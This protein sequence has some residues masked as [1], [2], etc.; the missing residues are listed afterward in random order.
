[1]EKLKSG[2]EKLGLQLT[3]AHLKQFQ[4]YY[5]ELI[6]WNRR[7]NLTAITDYSEVQVKH[8]LDSLTVVL[9]LEQPLGKGMKLI[10]VGTGAG[11]PGIPLKIVWPDIELVLLDATRKKSNFLEHIIQRLKLKGVEIV[12]GRAEDIAHKPAYRQQFDLVL[13]RA[14]A[15]LPALAELAL[16]FCAIGGRFI[17]QKKGGIEE[18]VQRARRAISILGGRLADIKRVKLPEFADERW[19]VAVDKVGETPPQYPRRPGIP[20]K[21]PLLPLSE[22]Y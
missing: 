14:V 17:A 1:M 2:A 19:L 21:R 15:G 8:F 22:T 18:E 5:Q 16:P 4:I 12:V 11:I 20:A 6:D 13:S 3:S 7:L 10:D 9:A